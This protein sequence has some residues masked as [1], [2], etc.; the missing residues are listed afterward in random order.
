MEAFY[1]TVLPRTPRIDVDRLDLVFT[2]PLLDF[3]GDKLRTI[4]TANITR[5]PLSDHRL[6]QHDL[7]CREWAFDLDGQRL[8]SILIQQRH[9][10]QR[11]PLVGPIEDK[12]PTPHRVAMRRLGRQPGG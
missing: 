2:Q 4:V 5:S 9:H 3:S 7:T 8:A 6:F 12:I 1:V 10:F 11:A